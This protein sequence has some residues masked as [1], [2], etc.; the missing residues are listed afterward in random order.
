MSSCQDTPKA[1]PVREREELVAD[2]PVQV[3]FIL[4]WMLSDAYTQLSD[5]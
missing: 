3:S 4:S 5:T 1:S 2:I